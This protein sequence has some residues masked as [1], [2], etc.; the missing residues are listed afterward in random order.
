MFL[1]IGN[2]FLSKIIDTPPPPPPTSIP[3]LPLSQ[4]TN[5]NTKKTKKNER[6]VRYTVS[7][8]MPFINQ[9]THPSSN[10]IVVGIVSATSNVCP[11]DAGDKTPVVIDDKC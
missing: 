11:N 7:I 1:P 9:Q 2:L 3:I 4:K 6:V 10:F 8:C 5:A